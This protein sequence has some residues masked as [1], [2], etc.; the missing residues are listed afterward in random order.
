MRALVLRGYGMSPRLGEFREP[1]S[2]A[3]RVDVAVVAAG[4]NPVDVAI[5][6]GQLGTGDPVPRV[7]GSEAVVL[8]DGRAGY[9]QQL[10]APFGAFAER[11]LVDPSEL[12]EVPAGVD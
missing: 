4:L 12:I 11:T 10:R 3:G 9:T 2:E 8:L 5:A 6:A 1:R 7:V